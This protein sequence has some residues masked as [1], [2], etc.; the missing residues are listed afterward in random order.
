M[1]RRNAIETR[2]KRTDRSETQPGTAPDLITTGF[3]D[4]R[5][6]KRKSR[7]ACFQSRVFGTLRFVFPKRAYLDTKVATGMRVS[8][9][10][11]S[12]LSNLAGPKCKRKRSSKRKSQNATK[13]QT[14]VSKRNQNAT[15][16]P[17]GPGVPKMRDFCQNAIKT[18]KVK[19]N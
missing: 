16:G 3:H 11:P 4:P 7:N 1:T 18:Q 10:K 8:R 14:P 13:T 17:A 12:E 9:G 19:R 6:S 5:P 15:Q 2:R